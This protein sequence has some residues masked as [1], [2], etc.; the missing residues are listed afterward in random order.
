M[1]NTVNAYLVPTVS[2]TEFAV[3]SGA[4]DARRAILLGLLRGAASR[5]VPL[6]R[7]A[8][9]AEIP[10]RK[11]VGALLF[12]MQREG[13]LSGDVDPLRF[14]DNALAEALPPL[15]ATLSLHGKAVL[16]DNNGLCIAFAGFE[17]PVA[18]ELAALGAG[19]FP[20]T[21]R[22]QRDLGAAIPLA[23]ATWSLQDGDCEVRLSVRPLHIG[24]HLFHLIQAG[25]PV[26]GSDAFLHLVAL[27]S[28]RYLG[29]C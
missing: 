3:A 23:R 5:P 14:P 9:L 27:L 20:L 28:R 26:T 19:L 25:T 1:D 18:D 21:R 29:E 7:L 16:A 6:A 24:R 17:R 8:E 13:W 10:D 22:F 15:L 4:A 2:G 12:K 11:S